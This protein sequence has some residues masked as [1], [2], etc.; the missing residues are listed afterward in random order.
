MNDS[1][2]LMVIVIV[3][4]IAFDFTDGFH[5]SANAIARRQHQPA[6]VALTRLVV[7]RTVVVCVVAI[8]IGVLAM[9]Q[10]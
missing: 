6:A 1:V 7:G 8:V 4:A 2:L 10:M 9:T 3:T 5:D